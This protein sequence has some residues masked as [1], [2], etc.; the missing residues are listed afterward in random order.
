MQDNVISFTW[1][2]RNACFVII[3]KLFTTLPKPSSDYKPH[4]KET[5]LK[6]LTVDDIHRCHVQCLWHVLCRKSGAECWSTS[7]RCGP[8]RRPYHNAAVGTAS[9][10][11][12]RASSARTPTRRALRSWRR[13]RPACAVATPGPVEDAERLVSVSQCS[14]FSNVVHEWSENYS[15]TFWQIVYLLGSR[16]GNE[17]IFVFHDATIAL[18][19]DFLRMLQSQYYCIAFPHLPI[20]VNI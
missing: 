11:T 20:T 8:H 5:V 17:E 18:F 16:A 13:R 1:I 10:A 9:P 15:R 4:N 12:W 6:L 14:L 7:P 3:V 19:R 2:L